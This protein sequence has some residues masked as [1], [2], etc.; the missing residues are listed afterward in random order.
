MQHRKC[1]SCTHLQNIRKPIIISIWKNSDFSL[2]HSQCLQLFIILDPILS[3]DACPILA[4]KNSLLSAE[5][6]WE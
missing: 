1:E 6:V 5:T 2:I 4:K 3:E